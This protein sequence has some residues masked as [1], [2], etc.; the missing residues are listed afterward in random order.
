MKQKTQ[1][2]NQITEGIIWRQL[3]LFF[4]PIVFGTFFQ[5]LYN[6]IDT[7]IVGQFVGKAALAS[8]GGSATQLINLVVG[9]FTGLSSGA[10][11]V[12][13]QFFGAKDE[14][15]VKESLH[16]AYAFSILG[17]IV[18]SALGIGLAPQLLRWMNT[19]EELL[20]DSTL[21][22][23]I[24]FA[25]ILFVFIFNVGSSILRA[26][27]DSKNPLYYL[28]ACCF[29]NIFLDLLFV[30]VFHLGVAGVAYAT[31]LS[32]AISALLVTHK[33]MTSHS[34]LTLKIR[35][36]RLHKNVLKSQLWIGLPAGFQSVMYS[37]SNVIIQAALNRFGTD[38]VA[39]W[40]AYGKLDAIFWMVSGA[41][42]IS[43]TT[44]VGQ[45]YGARKY[46]R[47]H[48]SVRICLG[49]DS[50]ISVILIVFLMLFR[51]PLFRLFTQDP[52]VIRIGSDMLALITPCYIFF[53]FIEVLAGALRGMGDVMIPTLITLLGVCVLRLIWIAVV[54]Q[55]SPTVNAIIYSYPVTWIAT[56]VLFIIYYLYKKKRILK[57]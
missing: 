28:I 9:F 29:I 53:V 1:N 41:I 33:L 51:V 6:T 23:R 24:Y 25:G 54:L 30:I 36:I 18:I 49:I 39:A 7:V 13:A 56:A 46:D 31:F 10:S 16:T 17:S 20:A 52:S 32:Q 5:Q 2:I 55:I 14:R 12:I 8:V 47:V 57:A 27:G 38:T 19:P 42:G 26:V 40:S 34:I 11:V 37:I 44:F 22:L 50:I 4:F 43:I 3:L 21:Y 15:S 35:D 45:N 48:K